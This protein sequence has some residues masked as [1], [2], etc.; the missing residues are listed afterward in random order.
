MYLATLK[1]TRR[2]ITEYKHSAQKEK[3]GRELFSSI[4][5]ANC[6]GEG[7]PAMTGLGSKTTIGQLATYLEDP[8][9][10]DRSGRMPGMQLS[11]EEAV[12]LADH[13]TQS[14][15]DDFVGTLP[16]GAD[17]KHGEQLLR[18]AGCLN[19]HTIDGNAGKPLAET[20]KFAGLDKL[21]PAKGCL[22]E[23]P[24]EGSARYALAAD[25]RKTA[26]AFLAAIK[27]A[28][29]VSSAP[30]HEFHRTL[31]KLN[32]AACHETDQAKPVSEDAEKLPPLTNVGAKLKRDWIQQVLNDKKA[33][34]RFWLKTRM[35]EFGGAVAN[36]AAQALACAGVEENDPKIPID[37][38]SIAR[39]QELVGANDP[40]K[41]PTGLGCVTCHSLR[42]FKP[43]V[44]ADATRGPELTLMST[45]LRADF[46]RRWMH[47]PARIQPGTAMPN[48]FT[49]K[50]R[51]EADL[52]TDVLW[53]YASLGISM[54]AP[55]GIKEKR[56]YVLIVTDQPLV[57][58]CQVP[59]PAGTIVY[60]ISVGLPQM[61]NYTF[62]AEH[63]MFR[64]AWSGG[65][66]DMGG[67]WNDRGGNPV[68]ILGPRFYSQATTPLHIGAADADES[69]A[70]KG[71]E[72]K[73]K[74]PT[75]IYTVGG[76]EVRERITALEGGV[77]IIRTFELDP[78]NK[79]VFFTATDDPSTSLSIA[80]GQFKAAQVQKSFK[81][82]DKVAGQIVEFPYAGK[83]TFVV[84]IRAKDPK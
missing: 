42:E 52:V 58:R 41:N 13:L 46:F 56:N 15:A 80:N 10:V 66:L 84:T 31:Q 63:V 79:P 7:G 9:S 60:G 3:E 49:D 27:T 1:D 76:V 48:F 62:D 5:C 47:E 59:D 71:Y 55:K 50:S 44:A 53:S 74:I 38:N 14:K 51:E 77:G 69:R 39:G 43:A 18:T 29:L 54:P 57:S 11:R 19:C 33:R 4:G 67:D 12:A 36:V 70:F 68:R 23:N 16:E 78:V 37:H 17:V 32:C 65:F 73:D 28:P 22:A 2:R 21:D 64:A 24:P 26:A 81:L 83:L 40:K 82:T 25:D 35:P 75:F 8:T 72:L 61:V 20:K 6:H 34:V 30:A 45:R